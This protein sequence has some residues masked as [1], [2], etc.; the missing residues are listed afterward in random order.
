MGGTPPKPVLSAEDAAR[1]ELAWKT[2]E[3]IGQ[4]PALSVTVQP[5]LT[6]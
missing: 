6:S 2:V 3:S 1:E 4:L 5:V